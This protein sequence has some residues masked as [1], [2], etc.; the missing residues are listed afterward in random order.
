MRVEFEWDERKRISNL[1]KH[2]ADFRDA[3]R[4]DLSRAVIRADR[5]RDYGEMREIALAMLD[6]RVHVLVFTMRGGVTRVISLRKAKL[7]EIRDYEDQVS[8][9]G[10]E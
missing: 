7:E 5:R 9:A 4:I 10:G 6:E 1:A 8:D 3:V 2:G